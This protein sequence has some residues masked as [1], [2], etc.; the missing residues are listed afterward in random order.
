M[1][2]GVTLIRKGVVP[3]ETMRPFSCC[4]PM[5]SI[6]GRCSPL[7]R[8]HLCHCHS[9]SDDYE[10]ILWPSLRWGHGSTIRN[11]SLFYGWNEKGKTKKHQFMWISYDI[12]HHPPHCQCTMDIHGSYP[13]PQPGFSALCGQ[14][15]ELARGLA[16]PWVSRLWRNRGYLLCKSSNRNVAFTYVESYTQN[17][18]PTCDSWICKR[19]QKW[20]CRQI[21]QQRITGLLGPE[22]AQRL[23]NHMRPQAHC[24]HKL[25]VMLD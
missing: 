12:A 13:F 19:C 7:T 17:A 25:R 22:R 16:A 21:P 14:C 11:D 24:I 23:C 20:C 8:S 5:Y 15:D 2:K 10:M 1:S 6:A 18:M 3:W 9:F 4:I